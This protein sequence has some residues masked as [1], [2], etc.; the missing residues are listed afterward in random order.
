MLLQTLSNSVGNIHGLGVCVCV[1]AHVRKTQQFFNLFFG[2]LEII[3]LFIYPC[4]LQSKPLQNHFIFNS[5]FELFFNEISPLKI[6]K[7]ARSTHF[8]T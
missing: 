2:C 7:K 5:F 3:Y 8:P 1:G 4:F 6:K